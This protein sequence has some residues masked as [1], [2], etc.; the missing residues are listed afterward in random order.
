MHHSEQPPRMTTTQGSGNV[1]PMNPPMDTRDHPSQYGGGGGSGSDGDIVSG[2]LNDVDDRTRQ[3]VDTRPSVRF[4]EPPAYDYNQDVE[5]PPQMIRTPRS[6]TRPMRV[7]DDEDENDS[8]AGSGL[9]G[10]RFIETILKET[11][12]PVIVACLIFIAGLANADSILSRLIP[13]LFQENGNGY[14]G[15]IVKAVIGG[16][17]FYAIRRLF[18]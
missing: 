11:Q 4:E 13:A 8:D 15:L 2:I 17:L 6:R 5:E 16:L 9:L 10:N 12:L 1:P 3:P 7:R 14:S 18:M